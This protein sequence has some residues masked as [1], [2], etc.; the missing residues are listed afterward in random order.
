M[1]LRFQDNEP[2]LGRGVF[3]AL[4]LEGFEVPPGVL[5]AGAPAKVKRELTEAEV[6][7]ISELADVYL[8]RARKR[9]PDRTR[10]GLSW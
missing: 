6:E 8:G 4:N 3:V 2:Q 5:V 10:F 1:P 9:G 7:Y